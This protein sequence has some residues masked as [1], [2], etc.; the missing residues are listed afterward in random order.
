MAFVACKVTSVNPASAPAW[1]PPR[2][3]ALVGVIA[4]QFAG[5]FVW[6]MP[7]TAAP[8]QRVALPAHT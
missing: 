1:L 7:G 3:H 5:T 2:M 8:M 4:Q 6:Y